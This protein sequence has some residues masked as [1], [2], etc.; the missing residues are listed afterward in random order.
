MVTLPN[1]VTLTASVTDDGL[2]KPRPRRRA[3]EEAPQ[4]GVRVKWIMYRGPGK[5]EFDPAVSPDVY[6]KP[7]SLTSKATFSAPGKYVLQAIA[8]D[9]QLY[10]VREVAVIVN[11]K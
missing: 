1:A 5:V 9:G 8:T 6:G 10:S 3:G 7:L 2:P 11:A 4:Q